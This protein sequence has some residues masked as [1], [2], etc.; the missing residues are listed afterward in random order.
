[1]RNLYVL[2]QLQKPKTIIFLKRTPIP[3]DLPKI[4]IISNYVIPNYLKLDHKRISI[5]MKQNNTEI[6]SDKIAE[7]SIDSYISR[8]VFL[9]I[10]KKFQIVLRNYKGVIMRYIAF[11]QEDKKI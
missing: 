11:Y 3:T 9:R 6:E 5:N 1:M 2:P 4:N 8:R 7:Q 10:R